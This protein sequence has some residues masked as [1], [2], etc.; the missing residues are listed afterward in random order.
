MLTTSITNHHFHTKINALISDHLAG[1]TIPDVPPL[2]D[3]DT[4][5]EP[6]ET[7]S[8]LLAFTSP[9]IDLCSPDPL[10]S[11]IS[12]Q[13]LHLEVAYAAFCGIDLVFVQGP[14]L[15]HRDPLTQRDLVTSN[16][17]EYARVIQECF[18]IGPRLHISI[19]LQTS[20]DKRQD[21]ED[22]KILKT[23]EEFLEEVEEERPEKTDE[24]GTWD[25]WNTIRTLCKY[26]SRLFVGKIQCESFPSVLQRLVAFDSIM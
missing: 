6:G 24:L 13:I 12:K 5:I 15:Y 14:K 20:D 9:W 26:H 17:V 4:D 16:I 21:A 25:A 11:G 2:T 10:I 3:L 18:E 22:E 7:T 23:R 19:I 8:S 1:S